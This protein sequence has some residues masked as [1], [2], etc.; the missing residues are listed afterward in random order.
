MVDVDVSPRHFGKRVGRKI[1]SAS[2]V[3]LVAKLENDLLKILLFEDSEENA[4]VVEFSSSS[5]E[6]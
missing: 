1:E 2:A 3:L 5:L 6:G 4:Y